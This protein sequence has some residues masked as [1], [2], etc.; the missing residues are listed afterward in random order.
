M[1]KTKERLGSTVRLPL[2]LR[3]WEVLKGLSTEDR[4]RWMQ[5]HRLANG[6]NE[7]VETGAALPIGLLV[8]A[9]GDVHPNGT[10]GVPEY[11]KRVMDGLAASVFLATGDV[12]STIGHEQVA[13]VLHKAIKDHKAST[14]EKIRKEQKREAELMA[15]IEERKGREQAYTHDRKAWIAEHGSDRL[16]RAVELNLVDACDKVYREERLATE[17]KGWRWYVDGEEH[18]EPRNPTTAEMDLLARTREWCP[19][20]ELVFVREAEQFEDGFYVEEEPD[21][22]MAVVARILNHTAVYRCDQDESS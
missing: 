20:A 2:T 12:P 17:Y 18:L 14:E 4:V 8:A 3:P 21:C 6:V 15:R 10:P 16:K 19:E 5:Q 22:Y 1:S 13:P 11:V 9:G 7:T